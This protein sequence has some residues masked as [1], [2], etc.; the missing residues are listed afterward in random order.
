MAQISSSR[1][2]GFTL[3]ELMISI[4]LGLIT[5]AAATAIYILIF[6]GSVNAIRSSKLN[7]DIDALM[8]LITTDLRRAGY[9]GGAIS[10]SDPKDNP[11]TQADTD[12]AINGQ[13]VTYT[14][15]V[16]SDGSLDNDN[17]GTI[18]DIDEVLGFKLVDGAIHVRLSG[19]DADDCDNGTWQEITAFENNEQVVVTDFT[20]STSGATPSSQCDNVSDDVSG[21]DPS[22]DCTGG[23]ATAPA[24]GDTYIAR[25]IIT[26]GISAESGRD[27]DVTKQL[28][29][30]VMVANDLLR[31]VP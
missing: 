8:T 27:G 25:R 23:I 5:I 14:Y 31:E 28:N 3:I 4:T 9:W 2:S 6:S 19:T 29:S 26:I 13:C 12:I 15:D 10:G 21:S 1:Q 24:T 18:D 30:S 17:D 16:D 7:Y 20:V 11:F 22:A